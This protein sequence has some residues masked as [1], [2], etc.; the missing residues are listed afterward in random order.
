MPTTILKIYGLNREAQELSS[1]DLQLKL[2][3]QILVEATDA[4]LDLSQVVDRLPNIYSG[5]GTTTFNPEGL[6]F[7]L[8]QSRHPYSDIYY[9]ESLDSM[10]RAPNGDHF[11]TINVTYSTPAPSPIPPAASGGAKRQ[12][13]TKPDSKD[14]KKQIPITNP[15]N[16]PAD[17][18]GSTKLIM[19]DRYHDLENKVIR[20]TNDLPITKPLPF[21]MNAT[22]WTWAWNVDIEDFPDALANCEELSATCN[23]G[24]FNLT[25][26]KG[27]TYSV[28]K[29]EMRC[30][31]FSYSEEFE[32]PNGSKTEYH[33]IRITGT[34]ELTEGFKWNKPPLSMHTKDY[35]DSR[36]QLQDIIINERGEKAKE[37][38]PLTKLG[39]GVPYD[40]LDGYDED[41]F[42]VL[43]VG[44][45]DLQMMRLGDFS[46][47]FTTY[48]LKLPFVDE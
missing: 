17:W 42:G 31:G 16:R 39:F 9:L 3:E 1:Q 10:T 13:V 38:W 45:V 23:T 40:Q 20:H 24:D 29:Y 4:D 28:K 21:P 27:K 25:V 32:T 35:N 19:V 6:T 2:R 41:N 26:G 12:R 14:K 7:T 46:S 8:F 48:K 5:P 33:Y 36:T 34:F 30:T 11:W 37:P 22:V 44:S 18:N 43:Q 47:F 15:M